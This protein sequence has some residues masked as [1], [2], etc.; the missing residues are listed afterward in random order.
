MND[1]KANLSGKWTIHW[2][3]LIILMP[4]SVLIESVVRSIAAEDYGLSVLAS[5]LGYLTLLAFLG[6]AWAVFYRSPWVSWWVIFPVSFLAGLVLSR[7]IDFYLDLFDLDEYTTGFAP[8]DTTIVVW[9]IGMPIV[10]FV[11]NQLRNFIST[12]DSLVSQLLESEKPKLDFQLDDDFRKLLTSREEIGEQGYQDLA[13]KLR[14]FA[15]DRVRPM[16]HKLWAQEMKR[17]AKFPFFGLVKL[18]ITNNPMPLILYSLLALWLMAVASIGQFGPLT[19]ALYFSVDLVVFLASLIVFRRLF[20]NGSWVAVVSFP[21]VTALL[22]FVARSFIR[23]ELSIEQL[24]GGWLVLAI[25]LFTSLIFAGGIIQAN[26]TQEQILSDLQRAI[27]EGQK[28]SQLQAEVSQFGV[29]DLAKYIH[30]TIQSKLMAF[31]LKLE[32][33]ITAGDEMEASRIREQAS[34][35]VTNPLA[36]YEPRSKSDLSESLQAL[37]DNWRGLVDLELSVD[38]IPQQQSV[39]V[40]DIISEGIANA[41]KHGFAEHVSVKVL[42]QPA[43]IYIEITDDGIGPRENDQGYGQNMIDSHTNGNWSFGIA[44]NGHGSTLRASIQ[45]AS[46]K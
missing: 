14:E 23:P 27:R 39:P 16:S 31:S 2:A 1:L 22:I 13:L 30:G 35:L 26:R 4:I 34:E 19:G 42:N 11:M 12:R 24:I 41:H 7:G 45:T 3:P 40:F 20:P 33:A 36:E 37:S 43:G 6:L 28:I 21:P 18:A 44:D 46:S 29:A 17:K 10:G 8:I 5:F 38:E 32:Q 15:S 9:L 25:W